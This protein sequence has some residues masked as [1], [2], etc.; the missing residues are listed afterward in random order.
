[1][2]AELNGQL[3]PHALQPHRQ[4]HHARGEYLEHVLGAVKLL[5]DG[6]D[7]RID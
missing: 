3:G 5:L 4:L 7:H 6:G 1:M 2:A